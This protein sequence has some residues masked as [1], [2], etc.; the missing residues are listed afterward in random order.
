M[1]RK[2]IA[3]RVVVCCLILALTVIGYRAGMIIWQSN[4]AFAYNGTDLVRLHVVANSNR[5]ADQDLKLK[6]RDAILAATKEL[7]TDV[8][9]QSEAKR[10]IADNWHMVQDVALSEITRAGY[11]YQVLLELGSFDFPDREYG[12]V[13]LPAGQYEALKVIIG[14]GKGD[15]WWCVLFPPLCYL[16]PASPGADSVVTM[17]PHLEDGEIE[18]RSR[19]WE[20][21]RRTKAVLRFEA[22]LAANLEPIKKIAVPLLKSK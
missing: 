20:R 16:E 4:E 7:F 14:A 3:S 19:I 21:V 10:I 11:D 5:P 22:W 9:D 12:D 18:I 2:K 13:Y 8:P 15:N 17:A 6:V 1:I